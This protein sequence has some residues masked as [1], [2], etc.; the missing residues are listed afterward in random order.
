M[1]YGHMFC[2]MIQ[3]QIHMQIQ[4][5]IQIQMPIQIQMQYV[6]QAALLDLW[7]NYGVASR[8]RRT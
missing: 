5:Q 7:T 4:V 1:Q 6:K 8:T 3:I 2:M